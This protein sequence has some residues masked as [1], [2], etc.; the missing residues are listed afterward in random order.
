[1]KSDAKGQDL[2]FVIF[3]D[4]FAEGGSPL[5]LKSTCV[6]NNGDG[7]MKIEVG[8]SKNLIT[9]STMMVMMLMRMPKDRGEIKGQCCQ[10][11]R[12]GAARQNLLR[13]DFICERV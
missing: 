5:C 1:M 6:S 3:Y 13:S 4:L 11:I 8:R 10:L 12:D 2:S 9:R 7:K